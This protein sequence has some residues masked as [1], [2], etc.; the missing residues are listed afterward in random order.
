MDRARLLELTGAFILGGG[1][2]ALTY[3]LR[4]KVS[5]QQAETGGQ[6]V[7]AASEPELEAEP[8]FE[9][10][11]DNVHAGTGNGQAATDP[12][13]SATEP[14]GSELPFLVADAEGHPAAFPSIFALPEP[15]TAELE[16]KYPHHGIIMGVAAIV[17]TR[18]DLES[19]ILGTL[20]GGTRV[21]VD[22]ERTFG[23]G[24]TE[25]WKKVF[26]RGWICRRAGLVEGETP[27]PDT[28]EILP[29]D[30]LAPLPYAYWR[31]N[32]EM[33]PFFHRLPSFTEQ[34]QADAAGQAWYAEHGRLPMPIVPAER[35]EGVPSVVKEYMN[36]GYYVTRVGEEVRS[37]RHFIRTTRGAYA[38]RYQLSPKESPAFRGQILADSED[39]L[40]L[41]FIRRELAFVRR[42]APDSNELV[43]TEDVPQ[44]LSTYRFVAEPT[45]DHQV[46]YE[47]AEGRLIRAYAVAKADRLKRPPGVKSDER[48]IHV[49]LS[50]QTLVAYIG[51]RPLF[52]TLV[53]TG[54]EPGMTPVGIHRIIIK[55]IATSMRDQP[56]EEEAYS[57]DDVPWTQYFS[58]SIALHGAFWHAGYGIERSHGCVNLSPADARWLFGFTRPELP[59]DWHAIAPIRG[60][61]K[62]SPIVVT[63]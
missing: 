41:Y 31:V 2:V 27:P 32:E 1:L 25:G 55:H 17:R 61:E 16:T 10:D 3:E 52:A 4:T 60:S 42:A 51:D 18:P 24:C 21:R 37:E 63:E 35:P 36:A 5:G 15:L 9:P 30:L 47:D 19:E 20:R 54:K 29:P 46:Y 12:N 38:R 56:E 11:T 53:S 22:A 26:P 50:E 23:G 57:I 62:G 33:T 14:S 39:S 59:H 58:G 40:P 13:A 43:R 7:D 44:R 6:L 8:E 34:A 49:D 45:I 28:V 48:W